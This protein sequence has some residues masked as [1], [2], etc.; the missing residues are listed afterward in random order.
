MEPRDDELM[1][2]VRAGDEDALSAL[3]ARHAPS[4]YRFGVKLCRDARARTSARDLDS[5]SEV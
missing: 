2:A 5:D 1:T 3:L 4:V